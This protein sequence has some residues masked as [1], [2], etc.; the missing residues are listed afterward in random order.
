MS[1]LEIILIVCLFVSLISCIVLAIINKRQYEL[2]N[3]YKY[4][5]QNLFLKYKE[6]VIKKQN[7]SYDPFKEYNM[8]ENFYD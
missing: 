1:D 8:D 6:L 3:I 2:I 5:Y 4:N 7:N